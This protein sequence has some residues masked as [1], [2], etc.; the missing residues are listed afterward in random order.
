[1][2]RA[3][4]AGTKTQT[5]RLAWRDRAHQVGQSPAPATW[6]SVQ[7]GD[8]LW[9]REAWCPVDDRE[10]GGELWVDY[11]ATPRWPETSTKRAAGWDEAPDERG[12]LRWRSPIHMPR[13]ASRLTLH[14]DAVRLER[15]WDLTE[16]DARAEGVEPSTDDRSGH[17]LTPHRAAFAR[18]WST[19]HGAP[20]GHRNHAVVVLT[21][22]VQRRNIDA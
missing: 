22:R 7:A 21:F 1:M 20:F 4:L 18:L 11:R 5:R 13:W 17:P 14:V 12:A 15:L 9:V 3:L 16:E 10:H 19:L 8:R 6:Q 2:V